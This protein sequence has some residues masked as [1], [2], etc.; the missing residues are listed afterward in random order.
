MTKLE[1]PVKREI[2]QYVLQIE[3]PVRDEPALIK[4]KLKGKHHWVSVTIDSVYYL[5]CQKSAD[6][7][8]NERRTK[9]LVKRGLSFR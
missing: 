3:P 9:R 2:N 7:I 8:I 1:R 5:A 6:K 4:I